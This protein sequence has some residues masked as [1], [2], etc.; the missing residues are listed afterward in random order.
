M[1]EELMNERADTQGR[2]EAARLAMTIHR[3]RL[4]H[5][6][7]AAAAIVKL[8]EEAPADGEALDM[9]L[10]TDHAQYVREP[11]LVNARRALVESLATHPTDATTVRRLAKV[12]RALSDDVLYQ[13]A[14]GVLEGR[15]ARMIAE[16]WRELAQRL[17]RLASYFGSAVATAFAPA[18]PGPTAAASPATAA[19]ARPG[20]VHSE[21]SSLMLAIVQALDRRLGL[22]VRVHLHETKSFA[23]TGLPVLNDLSALDR[24][25][26]GKQ[27]FQVGCAH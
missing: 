7:G 21:A 8:L 24:S 15:V 1:L 11:L 3:D 2:I 17:H 26:L 9:L 6:Q 10:E 19:L 22:G 13:A 25:K 27:L 5:P 4:G 14:L 23:P 18:T 20:L 16:R 12:A